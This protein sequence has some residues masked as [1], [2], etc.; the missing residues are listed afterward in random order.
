MFIDKIRD[1]E[2]NNTIISLFDVKILF[3][4]VP[5]YLRTFENCNF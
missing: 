3:T 1:M 4:N 2:T 5:L